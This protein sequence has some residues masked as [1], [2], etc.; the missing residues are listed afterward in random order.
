MVLNERREGVPADSEP[1]VVENAHLRQGLGGQEVQVTADS[2]P[3]LISCALRLPRF[4]PIA[5]AHS[6][7]HELPEDGSM[8]PFVEIPA[9]ALTRVLEVA[10][11]GVRTGAR[12]TGALVKLAF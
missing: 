10:G 5:V 3:I 12:A 7:A 8:N 2:T 9:V 4:E 6:V 11:R 1:S